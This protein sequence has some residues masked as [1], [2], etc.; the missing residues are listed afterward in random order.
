[1]AML[2]SGEYSLTKKNV[3]HERKSM[4]FVKLTDS[5]Q[6]ALNEYFRNLNLNDATPQ[7]EFNKNE[8][9]ILIPTTKT[10][11][12]AQFKFDVTSNM[13][14][15]GMQ[16]RFDCVQHKRNTKHL[17]KFGQLTQR[18]RIHANEDVYETTKN[19]MAAIELEQRKSCTKQLD[20]NSTGAHMNARGKSKLEK[21]GKTT[22][23]TLQPSPSIAVKSEEK[24]P[25][26]TTTTTSKLPAVPASENISNNSNVFRN[27]NNKTQTAPRAVYNPPQKINTNACKMRKPLRERLVQMLAVRPYKK[28]EL[29]AV[30]KQ[31]GVRDCDK[32]H[33]SET[34]NSISTLRDNL[35]YLA[36]SVWN[37]VQ[38][39]WLFYTEQE[40]QLV[41]KNKLRNLTSP[42]SS[43]SD[44]GISTSSNQSPGNTPD[45]KSPPLGNSSYKRPGYIN[46]VD[47]F[48]TK[49]QRIS[50]F[51][52]QEPA[53]SSTKTTSSSSGTPT[54][55]ITDENNAHQRGGYEDY[56]IRPSGS[57]PSIRSNSQ[58]QS[59][60]AATS[61]SSSDYRLSETSN[62]SY[63]KCTP[64]PVV[65]STTEGD[66]SP[67][68]EDEL[69]N[70][71]A[72]STPLSSC[73]SSSS[74][75][76]VAS[77]TTPERDD[78]LLRKFVKQESLVVDAPYLAT[79]STQPP[80]KR[81]V[82]E[83]PKFMKEYVTIM[84]TEQR[85]KY[86]S[87][88]SEIFKEYKR[89]HEE[90]DGVSNVFAK[91]G[92]SLRQHKKGTPKYHKI[93]SEIIKKYYALKQSEKFAAAKRR[94]EY[95]HEKLS[96]IKQ[97][98]HEYDE[99]NQH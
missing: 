27:S 96:H 57:S 89:V 91:L 63:R 8:G 54:F 1:M 87:D 77:S 29:L 59:I 95:L 79:S 23:S 61:S 37:D 13:T 90:M 58:Q 7:I 35:H 75:A 19:R 41:A 88:F 4:L 97:L 49:R 38:E 68:A 36:K 31:E 66:L 2:T 52:R 17:I 47:G 86:K 12:V 80:G 76:A 14:M 16:G 73:S 24:E 43:S 53:I 56:L 71:D 85:R 93:E 94:F 78:S 44:S 60:T 18:L 82:R 45:E 67:R 30:L 64:P 50:H 21:I 83:K 81:N 3:V 84:N 6:R 72:S 9:R 46:G 74:S 62:Y 11:A 48:P 39:D 99:K 5:A 42:S 20:W 33:L 70:N 40:K 28:A 55:N 34:L 98:V 65:S 15:Q 92:E 69:F 10:N 25:T 32:P 22:T 51:S 26:T